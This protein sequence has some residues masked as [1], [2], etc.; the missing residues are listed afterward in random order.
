LNN[1]NI[2]KEYEGLLQY[3]K[4]NDKVEDIRNANTELLHINAD[5]IL[6]QIHRGESGWENQVPA[7]VAEL[8]KSNCLFDYPCAPE[9][10]DHLKKNFN[11]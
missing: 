10:R 2:A 3:L 7:K 9:T 1:L 8:I 4:V 11:S 6:E 5:D